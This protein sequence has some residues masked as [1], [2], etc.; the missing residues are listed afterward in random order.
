MTLHCMTLLCLN[1]IFVCATEHLTTMQCKAKVLYHNSQKSCPMIHN[2]RRK[3]HKLPQNIGRP[4]KQGERSCST[5][6][7]KEHIPFIAA[8]VLGRSCGLRTA[9]TVLML[10]LKAFRCGRARAPLV[11]PT[12][13]R[14]GG[15]AMHGP[16]TSAP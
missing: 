6:V 13:T 8:S 12:L 9:C 10:V 4:M 7:C 3:L 2:R 15:W 5:P 14:T 11:A 16:T 1:F